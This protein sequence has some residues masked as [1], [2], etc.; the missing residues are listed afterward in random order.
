M[1]LRLEPFLAAMS[2]IFLSHSSID[3]NEALALKRWLAD[4]GWDDVFL[5]VDPE[6]GL[7][8]GERWQQA[9]KRAD[10]RCEAVLF[11]IS[12]AW[13]RSKWCLAEFL[14]AKSLNKRIF[15]LVLQPVPIVELPTEMT[16]EWQLCHLFGDGATEK[17]A[18]IHREQTVVVD[19]LTEGLRRL[20]AGLDAAGLSPEYFAWPPPDDPAR[21]PYRGLEPL[22]AADAAVFFGRDVEI[23]RGLDTL[24]GMRASGQETLLVILA[25]SGAGKSSFLR[26]GLLPRL[27]RDDRHF[28]PLRPIRPE[29]SPLYGE[30]SLARAIFEANARFN[31][32]PSTLGDIKD[33]ISKGTAR[34]AE[35]LTAL[36]NAARERIAS[37]GDDLAA[38][39]LVLSVDQAEEL[40]TLPRTGWLDAP[41]EAHDFLQLIGNILS[42]DQICTKHGKAAPLIIAFTIRSDRYEALQTEASLA[43]LRSV[44]FD[45]LK[46][47]PI[48]Q[49][50]DVIVGPAARA[51][52]GGRALEIKPDLTACLLAACDGGADTL[53]L[54]SLTL[55]RLY[56]EYG[57]DGDLRLD[58]YNRMGGMSDVI[59]R[60]AESILSTAPHARARELAILREAFLSALVTIDPATDEPLRR[61]A[62]MAELPSDSLPLIEALVDRHLLSSD[63]RNG[64]HVVEVAHESI[65]RQWPAL[66]GWLRDERGDLKEVDRLQHA[67][68][69][70]ENSGRKA[71]WLMSGERLQAAE[72]LARHPRYLKRLE[73]ASAFLAASR[74]AEMA[75]IA[76]R[77]AQQR[78]QR[79]LLLWI[80]SLVAAAAIVTIVGAT[81]V[82]N[83]QRN[84][85]RAQSLT[86]ARASQ[87]L[88][89]EDRY[90]NASR[91]AILATHTNALLPTTP[92]AYAALSSAAQGN[93]HIIVM[94]KFEGPVRGARFSEDERRILTWSDFG[95][96]RLW[97]AATGDQIGPAADNVKGALFSKDEGRILTWSDDGSA[98]LWDATTGD[99][100]GTEL[101]HDGTVH[102]AMFSKDERRI[103]TWSSDGSARLWDTVTGDQIG[104]ELKHNGDVVGAVFSK[105]ERRILTWSSDGSARLWDAA[106]GDQIGLELKHDGWVHGTVFSKDE[107]RILTWS[108]DGSARLWDTATGD[109]I[110]SEL[111]HDSW[112]YGAAFSKDERRILTWSSDGSARL[113]DAATGDQIG[114]KLRHGGRV[115]GAVFSK[116]E[117][118]ILTWSSD[119][120]A[121]LWDVATENQ[122]GPELKH[123]GR[124]RGAVFSKDERRILTWSSDGSVRLWDAATGDQVGPELKHDDTVDGAVFSKDDR[125]ILTWSREKSARLWDTATG[126]QIG[127]ELKHD[128]TVDGA[129][130]SE[131]DRRILTWSEDRCARLWDAATGNQIGPELRHGGR[132]RGAVFSKDEYRILTWSSDGSARLWDAATGNQ[133]GP[134]LKH[135]GW[136]DGAVFSKDERRI[137]TWSED[138][139]ARLWDAATGDQIGPELKHDGWVHG[140]V[141]SKDERRILTWSN[142]GS[143]RL[144][145]TATG[146]QIGPELKH[147]SDVVGAVFSKNERRIL[148]WSRDGSARLWD[149]TTG[150]QFGPELKHGGWVFG[151]V[152]SKDERRILTWSIDGSVRLWDTAT[153]DQIGVTSKHGGSVYGGMFSKDERSILIWLS[154][155]SM[156]LWDVEWAMRDPINANFVSDLC[157]RKLVGTAPESIPGDP[158]EPTWIRQLDEIDVAIA[159][160][161]RGREG[162]NVCA[163]PPS[164]WASL[165][166][167][168]GL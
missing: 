66:A 70:W 150:N 58:E 163:P 105:D 132:V 36:R 81:L 77:T 61:T 149:A 76:A 18:C 69:A 12:P 19:F 34:V 8:A 143:A 120:S 89:A 13:A 43:G 44:V 90:L 5:D 165:R 87:Q 60:E 99:Q 86:L 159:P 128:G 131:D 20:K 158:T 15:G 154:N 54:L 57:S 100:I 42:N 155:Y 162:E 63:I 138:R 62:N 38:P 92:E 157:A 28:L 137:L 108:S 160:I 65:F 147:S 10:D 14:L 139:S 151:A 141:F 152:F 115:H 119:G 30:H 50:K 25:A 126:D 39:T 64:H 3:E 21:A 73:P 80:G 16:S 125:R 133:L 142:D 49:F 47:M 112:V 136:V 161:L 135:G 110:G 7:I 98:R 67:V 51:T 4:N 6:R 129:V 33:A 164:T 144:W 97:D 82:L 55:A 101:K 127:P 24:R 113:W 27:R 59:R 46:P 88:A 68:A 84:L 40:F 116:D 32:L 53:P 118:R 29:N 91:L 83:G 111:K 153:G 121:R 95:G 17:V 79:R 109:Q 106:T 156:W 107:R 148:T 45:S 48:A 93:R 11:L 102:G 23:L 75:A 2:R 1:G 9:L 41:S 130:F 56:H 166:A 96:A 22:D 85:A 31:L 122:F 71:A 146:D 52:Q 37:T 140:A 103:L 145:D 114:P 124:V 78:R 72:A 168:V 104:P 167:L 123:G 94:G 74:H 134:E 26:A 117:R 35:L